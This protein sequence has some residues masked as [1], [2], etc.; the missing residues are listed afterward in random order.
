MIGAAGGVIVDVAVLAGALL[1][2]GGF[3]WGLISLLIMREL[4]WPEFLLYLAGLLVVAGAGVLTW[5]SPLSL[6]ILAG[7]VVIGLGFPQMRKWANDA[8]LRRMEREDIVGHKRAIQNRPEIPY[9][10]RRL[11]DIYYKRGQWDEAVSWYKQ[12]QEL[13]QDPEVKFRVKRSIELME[14]AEQMTRL[15]PDCHH[16]NPSYARYCVNC[17]TMLPGPWEI[18]EVFRGRQGLRYLATV[19]VGSLAIG[20]ALALLLG[21]VATPYVILLF[22][23]AAAATVYILYKRFTSV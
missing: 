16:A 15:C 3:A 18:V 1:V 14:A 19:V 10:Y 4:T 8:A 11:G 21:F 12:Y 13:T 2:V 17:G 6:G 20:T 7:M 9:A 22:W 23:I 5:G